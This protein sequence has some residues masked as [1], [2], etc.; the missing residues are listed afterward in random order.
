[1]STHRLTMALTGLATTLVLTAC[2]SGDSTTAP[3]AGVDGSSPSTSSAA[4]ATP[5]DADVTFA[6]SMIVHH[7]QALEMAELAATR[8][9]ASTL[10]PCATTGTTATQV[11]PAS[12]TR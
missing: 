10:G 3:S 7:Q 2:G 1:M 4:S 9:S 6:Q 8:A 11:S 5:D 12:V